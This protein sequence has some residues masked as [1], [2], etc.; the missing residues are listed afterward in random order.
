MCIAVP[1]KVVETFEDG[2]AR[3]RVGEGNAFVTASLALLDE[4]PQPGEYLIIHAGFALR[5]LD[6]ADAEETVAL[7]REMI[8]AVDAEQRSSAGPGRPA[9]PA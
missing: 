3:C 9:E 7:L 6:A 4:P 5:K 2:T 1:A 8:A